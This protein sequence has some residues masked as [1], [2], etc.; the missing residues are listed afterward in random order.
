MLSYPP[1]PYSNYSDPILMVLNVRLSEVR[2]TL[3]QA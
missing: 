2:L 3:E 1:K